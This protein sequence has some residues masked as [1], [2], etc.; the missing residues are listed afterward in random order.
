MMP[1]MQ[2]TE[3]PS[4]DTPEGIEDF[5]DALRAFA[6]EFDIHPEEALREMTLMLRSQAE[7]ARLKDRFD[8]RRCR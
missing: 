1:V 5:I 3:D 2:A 4:G 8:I 6:R 7:L